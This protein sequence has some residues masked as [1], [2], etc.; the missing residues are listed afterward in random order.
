M[1][2][3]GPAGSAGVEAITTPSG[4]STPLARR[5]SFTEQRRKPLHT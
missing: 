1:K 4:G 5:S 2:P 3:P